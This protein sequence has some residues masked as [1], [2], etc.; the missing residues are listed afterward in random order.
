MF[1]L[2][3]IKAYAKTKQTAL[4]N[5]EERLSF[6]LLETRSEAFAAWLLAQFGPDRSP[7]VI[8]GH[9]ETDFLPCMFG[10]LKAGRAYVP[11]DTMTPPA[12]AAGMIVEVGAQ[13]VVN[14]SGTALAAGALQ[15]DAEAL[16][17]I[18]QLPAQ[19]VL[20]EHWVC[21]DRP[22]YILFTSGSTGKPKGVPITANNLAGFCQ[23][24][25]PHMGAG[26]VILNQISYSFDVSCCAIYAGISRGMTLF[27]LDQRMVENMG[28]LYDY[29]EQSALEVWVSTPSFAEMC[30]RSQRFCAALMPQ[31]RQFLFCGEV[32]THKLCDQLAA[33]FPGVELLNT[34][35][36]TEATVLVTAVQV[37]EAM[38]KDS[39]PI[40]IGAPIAGVELRLVD[41]HSRTVE[42]DETEG[43]L[44]IFGNSV[45]S[46][47]LNRRELT[48]ERFLPDNTTGKQG[49][50]TGDICYRKDGLY[51]YRGRADNQLKISGHRIELED[52]ENNL[53]Q[54]E[55]IARAAVVPVWQDGQLQYLAAFLLLEQQDGLAPFK[56]AVEIKRK[57]G[58]FLPAYM[59]PRKIAVLDAFPLSTNGKVDRQALSARLQKAERL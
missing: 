28:T 37:T 9:K 31:L 35:G 10:A 53:A 4:V 14:F 24:L 12:R 26:G 52:I 29:L 43:E 16:G 13:V 32:L 59:I 36:P 39:R 30:V 21:G 17:E 48:A 40:P 57:A 19:E 44:L 20:R 41:S 51:Y 25:F 58:E 2:E 45:S 15:L 50:R 18:L 49:Y 47:Y 55:N 54:I 5:R 22:A 33:R 42:Q 56:R 8:Y 27:T 23:G 46:G 38:R 34:Y 11:I 1:V 6:A 3:S 7:V